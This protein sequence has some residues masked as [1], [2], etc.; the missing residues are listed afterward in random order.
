MRGQQTFLIYRN[1]CA[2]FVEPE[3]WPLSLTNILAEGLLSAGTLLVT[4][5]EVHKAGTGLVLVES[6]VSQQVEGTK[7][8]HS[9]RNWT[10]V[11]LAGQTTASTP[12]ES[13]PSSRV[14][15]HLV[16]ERGGSCLVP[17]GI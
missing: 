10:V 15:A 12:W 17:E 14:D 9:R 11:T 2:G 3:T 13:G 4:Q 16:E 1:N 6:R 8:N 5:G 7:D